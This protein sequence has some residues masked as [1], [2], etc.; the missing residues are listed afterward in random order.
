MPRRA[1]IAAGLLVAALIAACGGSSHAQSSTS[2]SNPTAPATSVASSTSTN[3]TSTVSAG[4]T[5]TT[6]ATIS[7]QP[8][9]VPKGRRSQRSRRATASAGVRLPA[10]FMIKAGGAVVPNLISAP[11]NVTIQLRLR[12]LDSSSHRVLLDAARLS[13]AQLTP[14]ASVTTDV[15]GLGRGTYRLL[16]DGRARARLLIGAVPGP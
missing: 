2:S 1:T 8:P 10:L 11:A 6:S 3:G 13:P 14:R 4:P 15:A 9:E 16:V 5:S 7:G 12:N